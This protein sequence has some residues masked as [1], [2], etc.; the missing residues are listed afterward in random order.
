MTSEHENYEKLRIL[1][2]FEEDPKEKQKLKE[3]IAEMELKFP[4]LKNAND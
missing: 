1:L 4:H 2:S 3:R